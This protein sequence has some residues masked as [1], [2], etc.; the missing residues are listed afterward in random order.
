MLSSGGLELVEA[1]LSINPTKRPSAREA[2]NYAY[3]TVEVPL[4]CSPEE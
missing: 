2:L 3:F 1:L 4:A